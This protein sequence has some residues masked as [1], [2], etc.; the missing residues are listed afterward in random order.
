MKITDDFSSLSLG[1]GDCP[2]EAITFTSQ[3]SCDYCL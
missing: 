3:G 1:F 2:M